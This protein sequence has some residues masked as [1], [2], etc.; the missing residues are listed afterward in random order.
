ML[1]PQNRE[2]YV[3][4]EDGS[5]AK[6]RK[7]QVESP[8]GLEDLDSTDLDPPP[9]G[10]SVAG[11]DAVEG[12]ADEYSDEEKKEND[13]LA[14]A[15]EKAK[16]VRVKKWLLPNVHSSIADSPNMSY[17]EIYKLLKVCAAVECNIF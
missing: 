6:A 10:E 7:G 5:N 2:Q 4:R 8:G 3:P 17:N 16:K 12:I 1:Y 11:V 13:D 9:T 15:P 14:D